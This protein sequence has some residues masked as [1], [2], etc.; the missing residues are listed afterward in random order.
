MIVTT[1]QLKEK[2]S[3][4]SNPISKINREIKNGNLFPLRK[5]LYE[6]E[7]NV[8]GFKLAQFIYGPSYLSFDY[9]LSEYGLIPEMVHNFTCATFNKNKSKTYKNKFGTFLYRDVPKDVFSLGVV[10]KNYKEYSYQIAT[11][12]KALCDK[13]YTVPPVKTIDALYD[14]L[15]KDLRIYEDD[16]YK[17]NREDLFKLAPLYRSTNLNFLLKIIKGER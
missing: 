1:Q 12:E 2:Y 14:L 9:A 10:V 11:P 13:L 4:Y 17:L 16:F 8:D 6:T 7:S 5:G 3:E 15:F